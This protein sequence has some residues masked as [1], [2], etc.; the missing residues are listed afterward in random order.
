MDT[1]DSVN[2]PGTFLPVGITLKDF[3][4]MLGLLQ[5]W[6]WHLRFSVPIAEAANPRNM[7]LSD[8]VL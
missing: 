1:W 4:Q 7:S 6:E 2:S 8:S 3:V 5:V